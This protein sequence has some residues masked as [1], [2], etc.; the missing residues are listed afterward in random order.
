MVCISVESVVTSPLSFFISSIWLFSLFFFINLAS[1][2]FCWSFQKTSSWICW[3]FEGFFYLLQFCSDLSYFLSSA[4]FEVFW[5]CSSSCFNFD[6]KVSILE[7]SLLLMWALIAIYFPLETTLNVSQRFWD[8]VSSF[9][10]VS[11]NIFISAFI[12]L[13]IQSIFKSQLFSFHEAVRFWVSFWIL[14]YNLIALWSERLF[15]MIS[16]L[17]HLLRSDLLPIM[18]SILEWVWCVIF[19]GLGVESSVNVYQVCLFQ[20]WVQVLDILVNFLSGWSV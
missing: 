2:L 15:V 1:G 7:L 4:G 12:S 18:W 6:D 8:V 11:K 16:V 13:F 5:S 3:F 17:L 9:S 20:V 14:S 10:L 19:C